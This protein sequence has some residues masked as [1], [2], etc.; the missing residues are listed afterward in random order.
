MYVYIFVNIFI[1]YY[2]LCILKSIFYRR[3]V[4]YLLIGICDFCSEYVALVIMYMN[5]GKHSY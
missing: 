2:L 4:L 1:F 3:S 5:I